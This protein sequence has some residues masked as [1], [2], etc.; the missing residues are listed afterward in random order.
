MWNWEV[1]SGEL[2]VQGQSWLHNEFQVRL[3]HIKTNFKGW[4]DDP[5]VKS[6]DCSSVQ[7]P[8]IT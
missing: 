4:R 6:T 2:R 3:E 7:I 1:D 8:A 5:V